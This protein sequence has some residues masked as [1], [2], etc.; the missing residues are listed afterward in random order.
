MDDK[1]KK[2]NLRLDREFLALRSK[3][4]ITLYG[5]YSPKDEK[6]FL[7]KRKKFLIQ[8]GYTETK[9]V[10]DYQDEHPSLNASEVSKRC[11][12]F[13][14]VNFLIITNKG[15]KLG[16]TKELGYIADSTRM[17]DKQAYCIVFD[18]KIGNRSS[19]SQL[20]LDDIKDIRISVREFTTTR[21]LEVALLTEAFFFLRKLKGRLDQLPDT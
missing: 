15:K 1:W 19:L 11:L 17:V 10:Q 9:I 6:A 4:T 20:S 18:Q 13:S 7:I 12:E 21:Q 8:N 14:N 16:V 5:S 3:L 2:F